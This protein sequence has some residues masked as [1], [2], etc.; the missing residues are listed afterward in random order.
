MPSELVLVESANI[1]SELHHKPWQACSYHILLSELHHKPGQPDGCRSL[2]RSSLAE[3]PEQA[4]IETDAFPSLSLVPICQRPLSLPSLV[5]FL[6]L[7]S[8]VCFQKPL[9]FSRNSL[10]VW[11]VRPLQMPMVFIETLTLTQSTFR[12]SFSLLYSL[13]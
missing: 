12:R 1:L 5:Y 6:S 9:R 13:Q 2:H 4:V 8:L 11:L 3:F 10:R 7:P